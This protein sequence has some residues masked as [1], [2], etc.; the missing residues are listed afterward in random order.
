MSN[1]S[2]TQCERLLAYLEEHGEITQA[3]AMNDLGIMRLASR[4]SEL[5]KRGIKFETSFLTVPNRYG[6]KCSVACYRLVRGDE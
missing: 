4:M 6:E 2:P 3:Q 5:K 1:S